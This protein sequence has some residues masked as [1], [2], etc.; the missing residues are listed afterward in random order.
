M[1]QISHRMRIIPPTQLVVRS[2]SAYTRA[3]RGSPFLISSFPSPREGNEE[4]E[5]NGRGHGDLR[6]LNMNEPPTALVGLGKLASPTLWWPSMNPHQLRWW[7]CPLTLRR[8][9]LTF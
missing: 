4:M 1:R 2:Y 5:N 3:H 8:S 6:R 9:L 7:D